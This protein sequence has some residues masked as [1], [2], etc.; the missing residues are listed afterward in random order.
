VK[1]LVEMLI[2]GVYKQSV[3]LMLKGGKE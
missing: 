3:S 1:S 2:F